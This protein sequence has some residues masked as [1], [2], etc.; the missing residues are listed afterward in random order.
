MEFIYRPW[1][2]DFVGGGYGWNQPAQEFVDAYEAG[3]K[4]KVQTVLYEGYDF[5]GKV[6]ESYYDMVVSRCCCFSAL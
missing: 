4:R 1:N 2:S 3:D 6:N 5:D